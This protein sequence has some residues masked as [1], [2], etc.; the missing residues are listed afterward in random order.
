[1]FFTFHIINYLTLQNVT[2]LQTFKNLQEI[3]FTFYILPSGKKDIIY[4][5]WSKNLK[6]VA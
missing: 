1:M 5:S 2:L 4:E 6:T 3:L